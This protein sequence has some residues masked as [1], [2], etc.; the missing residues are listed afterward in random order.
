M[1]LL[2]Q[3]NNPLT[4]ARYH[5]EQV[6][7]AGVKDRRPYPLEIPEYL[8]DRMREY[9]A[10]VSSPASL[11]SLTCRSLPGCTHSTQTA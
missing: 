4:H 6:R 8:Q 3:E 11:L 7:E 9:L 10:E 1:E 5:K 2:D